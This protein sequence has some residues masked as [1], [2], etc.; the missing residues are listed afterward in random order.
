[1]E[2]KINELIAILREI[3][4]PDP[5]ADQFPYWFLNG[6]AD[7]AGMGTGDVEIVLCVISEINQ[8]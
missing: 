1:M 3:R 4:S 8:E 5:E 7:R 2:D 6:V